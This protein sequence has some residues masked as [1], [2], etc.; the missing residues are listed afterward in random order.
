MGALARITKSI[1]LRTG[2]EAFKKV[3]NLLFVAFVARQLGP[4][5]LGRYS[6]L[7]VLTGILAL[8][9][10]CGFSTLMLREVATRPRQ[11]R[12]LLGASL[13]TKGFL[14]GCVFGLLWVVLRGLSAAGGPVDRPIVG[15]TEAFFFAGYSILLS[16]MELSNALLVV[17]QRLDLDLLTNVVQRG[18]SVLLGALFVTMG[19]GVGGIGKA[20]VLATALA[21]GLS[22]WI[23]TRRSGR[24]E[25]SL[26]LRLISSLLKEAVPL[27]LTL[28]FSFVYFRIDQVMLRVMR[29]EAELGW[30]SAA[31]RLLE[32]V[33]VVPS[34]LM[35]IALPGLSRLYKESSSRLGEVSR[36]LVMMLFSAGMAVAV[37]GALVAPKI[38]LLFGK[39]FVGESARALSILI[40]TAIPIFCNFVLT[41]V[42]IAIGKQTK[43]VICFVVGSVANIGL[44]LV[45][46]PRYGYA[47]A[48]AATVA[49]ELL[50]LLYA[51]SYVSRYLV[52]V[53]LFAL[54]W[55]PV[56]AAMLAG[57]GTMLVPGASR[58]FVCAG[59]WLG[60]Y[61]VFLLLFKAVNREQVELLRGLAL[62]R[63]AAELIGPFDAG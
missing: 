17:D 1:G 13:V 50:L 19:M 16:F 37:V 42:L 47:G 33:V 55:R 54:V 26:D 32:V 60:I 30:Y 15:Y 25:L 57:L 11:T 41:T 21:A 34:V 59:V 24:P 52:R 38:V 53:R 2:T 18:G 14:S 31:Y 36:Q 61:A 63:E 3:V 9:A 45:L 58:G 28:F 51:S 62:P 20:F 48:A 44:N 10:D 27:A 56:C 8:V 4:A 23:V 46:I 40:W 22:L 35:L 5:G 12:K 7:L 6:F 29:S 39:Q 43:I 49:T